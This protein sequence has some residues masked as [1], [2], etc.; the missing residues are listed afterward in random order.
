MD[1]GLESVTSLPSCKRYIATHDANGKSVYAD[2]PP[3]QY[4][5]IGDDGG[6]ARSYSVPAVPAKLE[7]DVDV[8]AY[9]SKDG[10]TSWT[11]PSIVTPGGANLLVVDLKPGA[12]SMMHQT[13]SIDFSICT[14]GEIDHELDGGQKVRLRPGDHIVQRGT[15]H[16]WI[17]AS[18]TEPARFVAVALSC[19]PFDIAGKQLEEIHIPN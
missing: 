15:M 16:R 13:V 3:Q 17:N 1:G 10:I 7:N 2:S 5:P 8:K 9:L 11:Q 12:M 19:E 6:L 18:K 4:M 14:I